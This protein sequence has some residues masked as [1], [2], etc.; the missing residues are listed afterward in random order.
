MNKSLIRFL[1]ELGPLLIFF[2]TYRRSGMNDG[3]V[4]LIMMTI[5]S[6]IISYIIEK[7]IPIIAVIG[8]TFIAV[9]GGLAIYFNNKIFFFMKPTFINLIFASTLIYTKFFQKKLILKNIF[10]TVKISN[11]GWSKVTDHWIYFFVFLGILN[12]FIWRTQPE[13]FWVSFKVFGI[14]PI[15]LAFTALQVYMI[16]KHKYH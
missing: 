12:E 5:V 15:S 11:H 1:L 3:I 6:V 16:K 8:A 7:K 13:S 4:V 14:V 9:F 2:L 10:E